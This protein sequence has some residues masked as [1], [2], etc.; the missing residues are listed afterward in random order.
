MKKNCACHIVMIYLEGTKPDL[1]V[2]MVC[3]FAGFLSWRDPE[4]GSWF[5]Q[6]LVDVFQKHA[7]NSDILQMLTKVLVDIFVLIFVRALFIS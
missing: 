1:L 7:H 2:F 6:S 5:I 3:C 4:H